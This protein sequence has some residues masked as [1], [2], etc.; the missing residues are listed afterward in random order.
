MAHIVVIG[1]INMDLVVQVPHRPLPGETVLGSDAQIIPGGKGAN[2][3]VA[4]ARLGGDV[5]LIG[6]VGKDAFGSQLLATLVAEGVDTTYTSVVEDV[7]SG[8]AMISVDETG[9][10]SIIVAPGANYKLTPELVAAAWKDLPTP[11][12]V[13]AQLEV[14]LESI[15]ETARLAKA[16]GVPFILNPA[17]GRALPET[18][19]RNVDV[20]VPNEIEAA[21]LTGTQVGTLEQARIAANALK[22]MGPEA[23][24]VT[25][26]QN[27]ALLWDGEHM[28]HIAAH[29]V[30]VAD[31]TAAGDAFV[32]ALSVCL[33]ENIP[34]SAAVR[35][36]NG[37]G[38]LAVTRWGAQ[39]AMPTRREL[40]R[41]LE[42]RLKTN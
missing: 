26:G 9:Q 22:K 18:L 27:G 33:A 40:D 7:S 10:N 24:V 17:P 13:V 42:E 4:A 34:L 31:T 35:M 5:T 20:L 37:A 16:S 8:I 15:I 3:A 11:D 32:G 30:Q 25:L 14:P 6:C 19:F 38:A 2:Q 29:R 39:P 41:F 28:Q 36:A 21:L 12:A 23:I 1:S